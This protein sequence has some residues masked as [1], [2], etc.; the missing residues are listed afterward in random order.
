MKL[1][2]NL[3]LIGPCH[4]GFSILSV[5]RSLCSHHRARRQEEEQKAQWK[6]HWIPKQT[7]PAEDLVATDWE[8]RQGQVGTRTGQ[9]LREL[10][11]L[12]HYF[13]YFCLMKGMKVNFGNELILTCGVNL[14]RCQWEM[15]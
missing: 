4:C 3:L 12:L 14:K 1:K 9:H 11:V 15:C 10:V 6:E 5:S 8:R 2:K 7:R 13:Y